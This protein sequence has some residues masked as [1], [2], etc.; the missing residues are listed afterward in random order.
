MASKFRTSHTIPVEFPEVLK[1]FVREILR[2][3]PQNIYAFGA[4]Y[5]REKA[6]DIAGGGGISEE[7][8]VNQLTTLFLQ[9]D[10][11][12]NGVL[13]KH[14]FKKLMHDASLGLTKK[15]IKLLYSQ[16]DMND[17]GSIEYRE[18]I[19]ACVELILSIQARE[20]ARAEAEAMEA[21]AEAEA[22]YFFHGMSQDELEFLIREAFKAADT[23]GSGELSLKEFQTFLRDLPLNLTKKEINM[24]MMEVDTN[25]DGQVSLDEF[26]P[27][28][29]VIMREM[30]KNQ[31]LAVNREPDELAEYLIACCQEYDLDATGYIR[32]Q[33]LARALR[34]A[35]LGL[36]KFQIMTVVGEAP[37]GANGIEY[38]AFIS[39]TASR[40][41][42]ELMNVSEEMQYK[43]TS[44]WKQIQ[45]AEEEA[46]QVLGMDR[47]AFAMTMTSIFQEYDADHSG[48][49]D[50][51]EFEAAMRN[52]GIPFND[53]QIRM[54]MAATDMNEDGLVEYGEFAQVALQLMEYV[55]REQQISE[56][57]ASI[58]EEDEA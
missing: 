32:E 55:Q 47:D 18:F 52:C 45:G 41:I 40:M 37:A 22:D 5:F 33:K 58:Q 21:E 43:R 14:E 10:V 19:P 25:Q 49:L 13:D 53:N 23:D 24:A 8:L 34:E 12:G 35:D 26:I 2:E 20:A 31:I 1:D 28:F 4:E 9:A 11:D 7:D 3:Q 54:L 39:G 38:E 29:H 56:A 51:Q 6:N 27:L 15:Q 36:T 57:M 16:A 46:E 17:D 48:Y 44:A 42:T 50:P 30:I